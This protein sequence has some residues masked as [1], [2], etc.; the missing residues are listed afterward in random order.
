[1][2]KFIGF[3]YESIKAKRP[4]LEKF[5]T[6]LHRIANMEDMLPDNI[7]SLL[8]EISC[9]N[10]EI[11]DILGDT[12]HIFIELYEPYLEGFTE[13]ECEEVKNSIT[14]DMFVLSATK[15]NSIV[16]KAAEDYKK[17]QVK[18]QLFKL[19][20]DKT[21][22]TKNPRAWSAKY[23]T[24]ILCL[25]D[26][27]VY[28][29]AK[30]A[31]ATMNSVSQTEA[32]IKFALA[33]IEQADF[34]DKLA[35]EAY[36]DSQFM[37]AIVGDYSQLL[38]DIGAIRNALDKLGIDAYEWSDNP[39]VKSKIKALADLEYNAGG[40]DKVIDTID[41]MKNEELKEWLKE[42]AKKDIDLGVKIIINGG[43]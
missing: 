43:K 23:Q 29:E 14:S 28:S 3:S 32:E 16:K 17:D 6:N 19:W 38:T 15:S 7:K 4:A 27:T 37:R 26:E 40:S 11:R 18:S 13:A 1:M 22:G 42:L 41:G 35:N 21:G 31:F 12:L 5:F 20:S 36:R 39:A 9:H 2:L 25:V 30:K 33:F 24:P 8:D 34:F 10:A